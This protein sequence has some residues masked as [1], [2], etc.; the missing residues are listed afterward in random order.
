MAY[1]RLQSLW[2]GRV[3]EEADIDIITNKLLDLVRVVQI[4]LQVLNKTYWRR[5]LKS[6][7]LSIQARDF[8]DSKYVCGCK[9][10][11][12]IHKALILID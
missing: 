6:N 5:Y 7:F 12:E 8:L 4:I 3:K 9:L 11:F 2:T 1:N 10:V